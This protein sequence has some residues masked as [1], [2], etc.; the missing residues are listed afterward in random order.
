[1]EQWE[2]IWKSAPL[3]DIGK[4]G[5]PD[6]ILLKPGKLTPE[7]FEVM[8]R[9]T[10]L[11]RDAIL[12]AEARVHSEGSFLRVASEIAYFHHERWNGQGYP[13]GIAGEEIPLSARLMAVAD[14]YDALTSNRV[15]KAAI[16]HDDSVD[17]I[18]AERGGH[19]DPRITDCFLEMADDFRTIASAF[20][21]APTGDKYE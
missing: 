7:E 2:V 4:V 8:K 12:S 18:R 9:H 10:V 14:V 20:S 16:S 5:I 19:F 15:Y 13:E 11:G 6:H 3:H 21:D 1:M 17:I